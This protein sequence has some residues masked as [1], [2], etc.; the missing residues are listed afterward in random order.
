MDDF[1]KELLNVIAQV[2]QEQKTFPEK[3]FFIKEI[4][5]DHILVRS[6]PI[7]FLK[8]APQENF[9]LKEMISSRE[10]D[11]GL[12]LEKY[13]GEVDGKIRVSAWKLF[14]GN[15]SKIQVGQVYDK[16]G[17]IMHDLEAS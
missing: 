7:R 15:H 8:T 6:C 13:Y 12:V 10:T 3:K 4:N 17:H 11:N 2:Q 14:G 9:Q 1:K 16:L 5:D